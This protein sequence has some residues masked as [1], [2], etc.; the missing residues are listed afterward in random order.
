VAL[1]HGVPYLEFPT[2]PAA[3]A[4]HVRTMRRFGLGTIEAHARGLIPDD[5]LL[6][7]E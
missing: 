5:A 2:F 3:L 7:A 4:S 1:R 6:P